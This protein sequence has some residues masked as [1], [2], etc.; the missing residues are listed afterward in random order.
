MKD[1]SQVALVMDASISDIPGAN[2][3]AGL[4]GI[5]LARFQSRRRAK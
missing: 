2:P 1:A 5:K 4:E 3:F